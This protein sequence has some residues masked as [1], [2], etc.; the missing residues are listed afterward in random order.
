MI[1]VFVDMCEDMCKDTKICVKESVLTQLHMCTCTR[2]SKL[3]LHSRFWV[4]HQ[5]VI[6]L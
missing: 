6:K 1:R 4:I 3:L 5:S 2:K